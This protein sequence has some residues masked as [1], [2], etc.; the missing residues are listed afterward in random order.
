ML[1]DKIKCGYVSHTHNFKPSNSHN[2]KSKKKQVDLTLIM[3][4]TYLS[5]SKLVSLQYVI[6]ISKNMTISIFL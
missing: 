1:Y 2:E 3:Y 5:V 6:D 4:I